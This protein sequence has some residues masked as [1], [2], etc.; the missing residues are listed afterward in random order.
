MVLS[1]LS[2]GCSK[3]VD[4]RPKEVN[5]LLP[6]FS[7]TEDTSRITSVTQ[8]EVNRDAEAQKEMISGGS[9]S[10]QEEI[11]N[12]KK[13]TTRFPKSVKRNNCIKKFV[14]RVIYDYFFAIPVCKKHKGCREKFRTVNFSNG[15]TL[16]IAYDCYKWLNCIIKLKACFEQYLILYL[17]YNID[18]HE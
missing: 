6:L 10:N 15:K 18:A 2:F 8:P 9:S 7:D 13:I 4:A 11:A 1:V 12:S 5:N 14:Y 17:F 16:A 3:Q